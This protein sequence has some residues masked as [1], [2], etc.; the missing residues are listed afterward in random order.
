MQDKVFDLIKKEEKRQKE[1]LEMIPSENYAS[2]AVREAVGSVLMNKYSEGYPHKRYYQGNKIAD[3]VEDLANDRNISKSLSD[4]TGKILNIK[5]F[6]SSNEVTRRLLLDEDPE[7]RK[8]YKEELAKSGV[9]W[10]MSKFF[11]GE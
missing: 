8:L 3:M 2:K 6:D 4:I 1:V 7:I 11:P 10:R 5:T 9:E